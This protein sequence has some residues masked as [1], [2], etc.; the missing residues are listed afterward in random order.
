[1]FHGET[2]LDLVAHSKYLTLRAQEPEAPVWSPPRIERIGRQRKIGSHSRAEKNSQSVQ[3][4]R[5]DHGAPDHEF[6]WQVTRIQGVQIDSKR[7]CRIAEKVIHESRIGAR[8]MLVAGVLRALPF[9]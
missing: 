6:P 1:M 5:F 9:E 3:P 2:N 8:E 7:R 4:P